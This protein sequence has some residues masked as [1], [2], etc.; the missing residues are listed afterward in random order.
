MF[1]GN[2]LL[3][4]FND[5]DNSAFFCLFISLCFFL[6]KHIWINLWLQ[7]SSNFVLFN[8]I[9]NE[10]VFYFFNVKSPFV[11]GTTLYI[12]RSAPPFWWVLQLVWLIIIFDVLSVH[13]SESLMTT[14]SLTE[15][16]HKFIIQHNARLYRINSTIQCS[17][18][19]IEGQL[20][21][22]AWLLSLLGRYFKVSLFKKRKLPCLLFY[23]DMHIL[24]GNALK[25]FSML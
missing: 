24:I 15:Y 4:V 25:H 13:Y 11:W 18:F 16:P 23:V 14:Y 8:K 17:L 2:Y 5:I 12:C 7:L 6:Y 22:F 19:T 9:V 3:I 20:C 10:S 21:T 1:Q